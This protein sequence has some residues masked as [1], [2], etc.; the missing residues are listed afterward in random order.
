MKNAFV[1]LLTASSMMILPA[2]QAQAKGRDV[3]LGI[4]LGIGAAAAVN[5][6]RS[7][8][9]TTKKKTTTAKK[10]TKPK[11]TAQRGDAQIQ[12]ALN[13][14]GHDAGTP[15][16]LFGPRTRNAIKRYQ[17]EIGEPQTGTLTA[18]QK[19]AL[20]ARY[21]RDAGPGGGGAG[22]VG[23]AVAMTTLLASLGQQG[24]AQDL[25][26]TPNRGAE[27]VVM[28]ESAAAPAVCDVTVTGG[29][30]E[31]DTI[32][33]SYCTTL[34]YA[35][36]RSVVAS[37]AIPGFDP[38]VSGQQCTAWYDQ[39]EAALRAAASGSAEAGI[40]ALATLAPTSTDAERDALADS[41]SI[42]HGIAEAAGETEQAIGFAAMAA[43]V[44]GVGYGEIV[45]ASSAIGLGTVQ[46][47]SAATSWYLWTAEALDGGATPLIDVEGYDHTP[48]LLALVDS[49]EA[50]T[51][52][53]AGYAARQTASVVPPTAAGLALPGMPAP[54][55]VVQAPPL[56]DN[57]EAIYGMP[58][59]AAYA[60]CRDSAP[61]MQDLGRVTCR[62]LAVA[63][64]DMALAARLQ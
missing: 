18:S 55:P 15:D 49:A 54:K 38:V 33:S 51:T 13:F 31:M 10:S 22:S 41:F 47:A 21:A 12:V 27:P 29:Q 46:S 59:E 37:S 32:V 11:T 25:P 16:G 17:A 50:L 39:N 35:I 26:G 9:T 28:V 48:L 20:L 63:Y 43:A 45:A 4:L 52:D 24:A 40:A 42:C 61:A 44:G 30:P 1:C 36:N 62:S 3:A 34:G 64:G 7:K 23:G 8:G 5:A 56:P 6:N 53:W 2:P 58:T 19:S 57:F 14:L 60:A